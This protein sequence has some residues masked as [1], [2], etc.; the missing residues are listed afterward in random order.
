MKKQIVI[1]LAVCM[2]LSFAGCGAKETPTG[3]GDPGNNTAADA[4]KTVVTVGLSGN[5][6]DVSPYAAMNEF[7]EPIRNTMYQS[8]FVKDSVG[9]METIPCVGKSWEWGD[10]RTAVIE[11]YDYVHDV[12]GNPIAAKDVVFSYETC[13]AAANESDTSCIESVT[14]TG[15]YTVEIR[16]HEPSEINMVKMLT[17]IPIINKEAYEADP[18]TTPGTTAYKLTSYI[19]G[20]EYVYEKIDNYWQTDELNAFTHQANVGKIVFHCIPEATQMTNALENGEIQMA[21]G[22]DGREA[23]R[24]AEGGENA[25]GF[26]VDTFSGS[27][28]MALLFNS[29]SDS[30]CSDVNLRKAILYAIDSEAIVNLVLYGAG[31]VAKDI[32]SD[33]LSGYVSDWANEDYYSYDL[34]KAQEYLAMSGYNGET[35]KLEAASPYNSE[36]ELI[37]TELSAIGIKSEIQTFENALWQEEKVVVPGESTLDLELDGVG[38]SVVTTAWRGKFNPARFATGLP[39]TGCFDQ[40]LE[41]LWAAAAASQDPA[42]IDAC[43]DYFVEQAYA[44]GLYATA[45][46]CVTV[47]T[48]SDI[49]Y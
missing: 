43:H 35:L 30:L 8:L 26:S 24:F 19:S 16:L 11:I 18:E 4:G 25:D 6:T 37:Q 9:T 33:Q 21:V 28:S 1:L 40:R 49:V 36:L 13:I 15:D 10:E 41:D 31:V 17:Y 39:Q 14:A 47:D 23:A 46:K 2:L 42:D 7:S 5:V 48:I 22:A 12:N 38:G 27:F 45:S 20:S 44:V 34:D 3:S 29:S 32:T